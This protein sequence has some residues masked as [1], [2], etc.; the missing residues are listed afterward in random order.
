MIDPNTA[1]IE[2]AE[3][4][5][6]AYSMACQASYDIILMDISMP[7]MDGVEATKAIRAHEQSN[8]VQRTIIIAMTAHAMTGDRE[9][10]LSAGMDDYI[11]KPV[12]KTRIDEALGKWSAGKENS[13]RQAS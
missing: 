11:Q 4:G 6:V 1:H 9:R 13:V 5:K 7:E 8:N 2:F 10:F 12:N 3:N